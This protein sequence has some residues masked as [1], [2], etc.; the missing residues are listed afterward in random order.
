MK[1]LLAAALILGLSAPA[2]PAQEPARRVPPAGAPG[3]TAT[4]IQTVRLEILPP[5]AAVQV[6]DGRITVQGGQPAR[7]TIEIWRRPDGRTDATQRPELVVSAPAAL[8]RDTAGQ[9]RGTVPASI[10]AALGAAEQRP[11]VYT[12]VIT[13]VSP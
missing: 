8:Q 2:V 7:L 13:Y 4:A 1:A 3:A 10:M 5:P 9:P 12:V 6:A 11:G